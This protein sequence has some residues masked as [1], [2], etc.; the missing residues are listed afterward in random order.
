M[1]GLLHQ[2]NALTFPN[3][4]IASKHEVSTGLENYGFQFNLKPLLILIHDPI[5]TF[6]SELQ[7]KLTTDEKKKIQKQDRELT[8]WGEN[9]LA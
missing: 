9:H 3:L 6:L 1:L 7:R 4:S 8:H 5:E 2:E